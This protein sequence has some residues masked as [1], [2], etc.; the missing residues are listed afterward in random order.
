MRE[1]DRGRAV[2]GREESPLLE[3]TAACLS[4]CLPFRAL[5]WKKAL[6][7]FPASCYL[8]GRR[9]QSGVITHCT[10]ESCFSCQSSQGWDTAA[11]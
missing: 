11:R 7:S 2:W 10:W 6:L 4:V 9:E 8:E 3:D 1:G 5:F